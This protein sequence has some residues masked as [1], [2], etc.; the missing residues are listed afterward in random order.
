MDEETGGSTAGVNLSNGFTVI[1]SYISLDGEGHYHQNQLPHAR[2]Y[3]L[4]A[5][6]WPSALT[7]VQFNEDGEWHDFMPDRVALDAGP[8]FPYL[9]LD[10]GGRLV[11]HRV[12]RPRARKSAEKQMKQQVPLVSM[13]AADGAG[14][15]DNPASSPP[16]KKAKHAEAGSSD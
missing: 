8:W 7:Q 16:Q 15:V 3:T 10:D 5:G 13:A 6:G 11:D 4:P 12:N 2:D 1:C 14:S 9:E